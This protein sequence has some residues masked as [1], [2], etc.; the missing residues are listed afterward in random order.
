[1]FSNKFN[2]KHSCIKRRK[3]N[4]LKFKNRKERIIMSEKIINNQN[5]QFDYSPNQDVSYKWQD[6]IEQAQELANEQMEDYNKSRVLYDSEELSVLYHTDHMDEIEI[7]NNTYGEMEFSFS[8]NGNNDNVIIPARDS[9][10]VCDNEPEFSYLKNAI[11]NEEFSITTEDKS[12][13]DFVEEL[14]DLGWNVKVDG[15]Y[16]TLSQYTPAGEDYS[17]DVEYCDGNM[18]DIYREMY[19]Y[20]QGFDVEDHVKMWLDAKASGVSGVPNVVD[21]VDD[22]KEIDRMLEEVSDLA[23]DYAF[24]D[25]HK[26][27]PVSHDEEER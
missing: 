21:L 15:D 27:I 19:E 22:A 20:Y 12:F 18:K 5:S 17:F 23:Y 3:E 25:R 4:S 6:P 24:N 8:I 26:D 13:D 9:Y 16:I 7:I 14:E 10:S 1:M 11:E 2:K